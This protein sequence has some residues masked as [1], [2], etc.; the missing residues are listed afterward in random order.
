MLFSYLLGSIC[1]GVLIAKRRGVNLREAGSG[2]VGSTNVLRVIGKKEGALT[3]AGDLL[4]GTVAVAAARFLVGMEQPGWMA[5][6]ALAAILGHNFPL[7]YRFRGGKGVA[8]TFGVLLAYM[9]FIGLLLLLIWGVAFALTHV[10][11]VGALSV[12]VMLPVLTF[13]LT[14]EM[15]QFR[16]ALVVSVM[17][18]IR[19]RE[20]IRRLLRGEEG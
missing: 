4:K 6:S 20:N 18:V 9:P 7:Y 19:H 3:L 5:L 17:M 10:S 2:N 12:A 8:T 1:F 14:K 16:F 15:I 11:S 13:F